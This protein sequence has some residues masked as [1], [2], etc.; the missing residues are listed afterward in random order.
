MENIKSTKI[1][2]LIDDFIN[3][4]SIS[5]SF[6]KD[7]FENLL[8]KAIL[9]EDRDLRRV[10]CKIVRRLR[11]RNLINYIR[12]LLNDEDP[13]IKSLS[14]LAIAQFKDEQSLNKVVELYYSDNRMVKSSSV[15]ALGSIDNPSFHGLIFNALN[16]KFDDV[17]ENAIIALSWINDYRSIPKLI[18]IYDIE[19][20]RNI[21]NRIIKAFSILSSEE[22]NRKLS[23]IVIKENDETIILSA[24]NSLYKKG[25]TKYL[26][27]ANTFLLKALNDNY[28]NN[29]SSDLYRKNL[30]NIVSHNLWETKPISQEEQR[31]IYRIIEDDLIL[32]FYLRSD[33]LK[34]LAINSLK[35]LNLNYH[36][37]M[38]KLFENQLSNV[39]KMEIINFL[40]SYKVD[41]NLKLLL[42]EFLVDDDRVIREQTLFAILDSQLIKPIKNHIEKKILSMEHNHLK[43]IA[44]AIIY[45]SLDNYTV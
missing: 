28:K 4:Y 18:E 1:G 34:K 5:G 44:L 10:A 43:L 22:I 2:T 3:R 37:L 23:E 30:Y 38:I 33:E 35:N 14:L 8:A 27:L 25:I 15:L 20:N 39:I 6:S 13:V 11:I 17:R 42:L 24:I 29:T 21:K 45:N 9:S 32:K 31:S 41:K 12:I 36:H 40:S 16:D 19:K 7:Q 26:L